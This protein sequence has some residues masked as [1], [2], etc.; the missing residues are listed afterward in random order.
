MAGL[1]AR[2]RRAGART[3]PRRVRAASD[4]DRHAARQPSTTTGA[5]RGARTHPQARAAPPARHGARHRARLAHPRL[6]RSRVSVF[7]LTA[8]DG[9]ARAG[10]L[11]TAHGD[12]PT[13]AFMPVGTKGTVKSI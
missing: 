12:V 5:C 7:E 13:P 10:V 1:L 2:P 4:A 3:D 6:V 8:T 11:H 9:L